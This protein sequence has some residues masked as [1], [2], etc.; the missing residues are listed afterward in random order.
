MQ[1][2]TLC[3]KTSIWLLTSFNKNIEILYITV[4]S[5]CLS[6]K[7]LSRL[8]SLQT[9]DALVCK[10][11]RL[12]RWPDQSCCFRQILTLLDTSKWLYT[13]CRS[14]YVSKWDTLGNLYNGHFRQVTLSCTVVWLF[15]HTVITSIVIP[16]SH[17]CAHDQLGM[18]MHTTEC[19]SNKKIVKWFFLMIHWVCENF[20]DNLIF[21]WWLWHKMSRY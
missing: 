12:G 19:E 16:Q 18:Y 11:V 2:A 1:I 7:F 5:S 21:F 14:L 20:E 8:A 6:P 10:L 4:Y 9:N 15:M 3:C 13:L 17:K